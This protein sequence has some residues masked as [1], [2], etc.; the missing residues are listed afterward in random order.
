MSNGGI[1]AYPTEAVFGLGCD[2]MNQQ[3]V[4]NLLC[5]KNRSEKK[6]LI[7]IAAD[8]VQLTPFIDELPAQLFNKIMQS[9]PGPVNWLLPANPHS[10]AYLRGMHKLQAVRTSNHPIVKA[11]CLQFGGAI[12]STSANFNKRPPAK[13]AI[14]VRLSFNNTIDYILGGNVGS[15]KQPCEIRNGLDNRIIR[16]AS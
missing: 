13:T 14:Q 12:V 1:I 3:A 15:Q 7:L 11:L 16:P 4:K 5:I 2:P 8:P 6:G 10:P 9:W